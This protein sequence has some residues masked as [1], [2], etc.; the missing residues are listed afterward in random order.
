MPEIYSYGGKLCIHHSD[1]EER[2]QCFSAKKVNFR[3]FFHFIGKRGGLQQKNVSAKGRSGGGRGAAA[4]PSVRQKTFVCTGRRLCTGGG[5]KLPR[6]AE[7][8]ADANSPRQGEG[9]RRAHRRGPFTASTAAPASEPPFFRVSSFRQI[10]ECI[11]D[12]FRPR[13]ARR[14]V[15]LGKS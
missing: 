3:F 4:Y 5:G 13:S 2:K 7:A 10:H 11:F 14:R 1:M 9:L 8:S 12:G 6:T 15:V